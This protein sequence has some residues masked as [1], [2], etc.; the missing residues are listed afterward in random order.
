M[1]DLRSTGCCV[2]VVGA[3]VAGKLKIVN[4]AELSVFKEFLEKWSSVNLKEGKMVKHCWGM[5]NYLSE[6]IHNIMIKYASKRISFGATG[7]KM[8]IAFANCDHIE[9]L[10]NEFQ[11]DKSYCWIQKLK[12]MFYESMQQ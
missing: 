1:V 8:R 5:C 7:Y 2:V 3:F 4:E 10:K 6:M 11:R 12:D 9:N